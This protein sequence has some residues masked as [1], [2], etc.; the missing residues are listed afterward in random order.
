ML[1]ISKF[2][3]FFHGQRRALQLVV[4]T[5]EK[6]FLSKFYVSKKFNYIFTGRKDFSEDKSVLLLDS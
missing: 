6:F 3:F 4:N 2:V 1:K 5:K